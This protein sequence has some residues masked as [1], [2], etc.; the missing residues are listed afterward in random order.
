MLAA[1]TWDQTLLS[2]LL[3]LAAAYW[4]YRRAAEVLRRQE[5]RRE[6]RA[7]REALDQVM[8]ALQGAA[9]EYLED[10]EHDY[11]QREMVELERCALQAQVFYVR[12]LAMQ[13]ALRDICYP[14][15]HRE[16]IETIRGV[17]QALEGEIAALG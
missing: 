6:L 1:I 17:I 14:S 10:E 5:A 2:L 11:P 9:L 16:A 3:T 8:V 7:R 12:D 13:K 4:A 15:R